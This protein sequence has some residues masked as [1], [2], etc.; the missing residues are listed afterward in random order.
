MAVNKI[1]YGNKTLIDLTSDTITSEVLLTGYTAHNSS[2]NLINGSLECVT[3]YSGTNDPSAS[4]G[5]D[6]DLYFKM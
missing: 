5:N 4:L 6:G 1:N 2:G 3:Y